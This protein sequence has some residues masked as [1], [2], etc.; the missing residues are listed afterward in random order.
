MW[1]G[2]DS[3]AQAARARSGRGAQKAP[4][5]RGAAWQDGI[6]LPSVALSLG[7]RIKGL[8]GLGRGAARWAFP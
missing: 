1:R 8:K 6:P 3:A 7:G 2:R 4:G 5:P